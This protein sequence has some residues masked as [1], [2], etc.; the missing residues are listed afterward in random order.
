MNDTGTSPLGDIVSKVKS[1]RNNGTRDGNGI[2]GS[3]VES[4]VL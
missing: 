1:G 3:T 2:N 4:D